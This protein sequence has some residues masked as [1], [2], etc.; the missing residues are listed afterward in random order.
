[1][2]TCDGQPH[3]LLEKGLKKRSIIELPKI[4]LRQ[5]DNPNASSGTL[6]P[7]LPRGQAHSRSGLVHMQ[8]RFEPFAQALNE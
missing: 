1:M 3:P 5:L 2:G 6:S 4:T 7:V 8:I